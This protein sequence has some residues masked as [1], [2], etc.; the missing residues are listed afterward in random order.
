MSYQLYSAP[1]SANIVIHMILEQLEADFDVRWVDRSAQEQRGESYRNNLNP[2][3]LIPVLVDAD[4]A[5]FETAA[6]ALHLS[7]KYQ[8]LA[9]QRPGSIER[10]RFLQWLF[11]LSNTLH[12]DLRVQFYSERH[13]SDASAAES[14]LA[15]TKE[16]VAGHF[17]LIEAQLSKTAS[18]PWFL[19]AELSVLDFYL[20]ALCRWAVLY[21]VANALQKGLPEGLPC[22]HKLLT[23]LEALPAVQRALTPQKIRPPY[24]LNPSPPALPREQVSSS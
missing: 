14:L 5:I 13:V 10:A 16:R 3:G 2:Q 7:D 6:I 17:E 11:Y 18:G 9:P 15:K 24:F 23:A 22:I 12:A 4:Q 19:G 1:D 21:P 20:G 8:M